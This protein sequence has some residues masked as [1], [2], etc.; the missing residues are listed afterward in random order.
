M[1]LGL[2][3]GSGHEMKIKIY[4]TSVYDNIAT[5]SD[6]LIFYQIDENS[7]YWATNTYPLSCHMKGDTLSDMVIYY[8]III[9]C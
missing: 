6:S 7:Q 1:W 8:Q 9:G 2:K 5:L 3:V 4:L